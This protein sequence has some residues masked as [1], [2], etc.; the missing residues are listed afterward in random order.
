MCCWLGQPS[1]LV[2]SST[3]GGQSVSQQLC[4]HKLERCH[5]VATRKTSSEV[6]KVSVCWDDT[7]HR[8]R[9]GERWAALLCLDRTSVLL[10]KW[11]SG[12]LRATL[13]ACNFHYDFRLSSFSIF[14]FMVF[15]Y[16]QGSN[17]RTIL[18]SEFADKICRPWQQGGLL[19]HTSYF[20]SQK[21]VWGWHKYSLLCDCL[22]LSSPLRRREN[23][24]LQRAGVV[25]MAVLERVPTSTRESFM[26][27]NTC[28]LDVT[29]KSHLRFLLSPSTSVAA[30]LFRL[31]FEA[32][33]SL[34]EAG[35]VGISPPLAA[36]STSLASNVAEWHSD[37]HCRTTADQ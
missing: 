37:A 36:R 25:E 5:S 8:Y 23:K 11:P 10:V 20:S 13:C 28:F 30:L 7:L 9:E 14:S 4:V 35:M 32:S 3:G 33:V 12:H 26:F 24:G 22:W 2:V 6:L 18:G 15:S 31:P 27:F 29:L 34:K 21:C 17:R 1:Q 16:N 19:S